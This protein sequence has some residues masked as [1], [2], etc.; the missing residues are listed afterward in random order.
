[1]PL[2]PGTQLLY[3]CRKLKVKGLKDVLSP[4]TKDN[5]PAATVSIGA[6]NRIR[7]RIWDLGEEVKDAQ[8][9]F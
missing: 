4:N 1:M 8:D 5:R 2:S 3:I 6:Y 7:I 9:K